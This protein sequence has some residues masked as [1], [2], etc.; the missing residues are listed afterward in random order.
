[1]LSLFTF[2]HWRRKWQSTLVFLPGESQGWGSLVGC[3]LWGCTELDP[4]LPLEMR[5]DSPG[6]PGMQPRD[7]CLPWRRFYF[8]VAPC[9]MWFPDQGSNPRS[10]HWKR[11]VLTTGPKGSPQAGSFIAPFWLFSLP[12]WVWTLWHLWH[13]ALIFLPA[14]PH[15]TLP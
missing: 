13:L 10:L 2:M 8:L 9:S 15:T 6:E 12:H 3:R 4:W 14:G 11:G 1:M 5:P 7:P